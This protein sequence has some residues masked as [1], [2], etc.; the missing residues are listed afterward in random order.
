MRRLRSRLRSPRYAIALLL[1]LGYLSLVV[2]GQRQNGGGA[3]S[4]PAFTA[5]GSILVMFLVLKWWAFGADR[6]ALAFTPAEIQFFFPAP[7]S[8]PALLRYKMLRAQPFLLVN[9]LVWTVLL[10]RR[11]DGPAL[12]AALYATSLWIFFGILFL[13]RLGVALTRDSA[14]SH[15]VAGLRKSWP[16]VMLV[17][18]M[19]VGLWTTLHLLPPGSW[20][21]QP[22]APLGGIRRVLETAPLRYL[23]WPFRL[24]LAPLEA[25]S[26]LEWI[27]DAA[28]ALGILLLHLI[29]VVR[30]DRA[31]EEAALEASIRRAERIER[32]RR[33]GAGASMAPR[34]ARHWARLSP[35]GHPALAIVWKNVTRLIRTLSPA[36]L[37]VIVVISV[38]VIGLAIIEGQE[39]PTL[40]RVMGTLALSWAAV[41]SVLGPQWVRIDLRSELDHLATL[42]TWPLSGMVVMAGQVLSSALV[43]TGLQLL[44]GAA[45]LIGLWGDATTYLSAAQ[46][47]ALLLP[48]GFVLAALNVVA[49]GIQ[50]GAALLYPAWVRTEIRPGGVE[51]VG[52]HV[53]TAGMSFLLLAIAALGPSLAGSA[54]AYLLW[55]RLGPW[56]LVPGMC[57]AGAALTLE[58]FLL[59]DWLGDRFER[60]DPSAA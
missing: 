5:G 31:F 37:G 13:H 8:R 28:A 40:L 15:G 34:R 4:A 1:G 14:T 10:R 58:S 23:A 42:R 2:Y 49:L 35:S 60:L 50:N 36:F 16:A 46:V 55:S 43:L 29:W 3:V 52:Q 21:G 57:L 59:L 20:A 27:G 38:A 25:V 18:A 44:L 33:Q 56:A 45:A 24:P 22:G 32:W 30:A 48:S 51:Q 19:A 26:T 54:T 41:L 11:G 7:V 53:L 17:V 47:A 39:D 9:V 12:G 6:T